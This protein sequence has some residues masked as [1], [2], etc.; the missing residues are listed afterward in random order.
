MHLSLTHTRNGKI[1]R[2]RE[3]D[4]GLVVAMATGKDSVAAWGTDS[5]SSPIM[6][7]SN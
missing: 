6:L 2:G 4:H 3:K 5:A 7:A 1:D